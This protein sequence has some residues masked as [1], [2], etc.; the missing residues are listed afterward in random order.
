[1]GGLY[2]NPISR[3]LVSSSI[4][5][6]QDDITWCVAKAGLAPSWL[7]VFIIFNGDDLSRELSGWECSTSWLLLEEFVTGG[8]IDGPAVP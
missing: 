2:E 1:V 8:S 4:P 7:N 3:R 6:Y 5:Y